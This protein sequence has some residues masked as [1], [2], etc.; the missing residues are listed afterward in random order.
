MDHGVSQ[1]RTRAMAASVDGAVWAR[2]PISTAAVSPSL[3]SG[4]TMVVISTT[5]DSSHM[6]KS[7]KASGRSGRAVSRSCP[8]RLR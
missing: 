6:P 5:S 7:S 3:S 8:P 1:A 2:R 4:A